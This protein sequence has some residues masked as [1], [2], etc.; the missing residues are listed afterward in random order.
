LIV[1]AFLLDS[2]LK[3][4]MTVFYIAEAMQVCLLLLLITSWY[5]RLPHLIQDQCGPASRGFC[6]SRGFAGSVLSHNLLFAM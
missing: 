2:I 4:Y 5:V 3:K 1:F 6:T